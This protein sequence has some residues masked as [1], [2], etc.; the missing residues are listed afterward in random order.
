LRDFFGFNRAKHAIVEAAILA[1][2]TQFLPM[3]E[4]LCEFRRLSVPVQKTAGPD[5]FRAFQFLLDYVN[6]AAERQQ[7]RASSPGSPGEGDNS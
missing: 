5:E 2:R 3:D 7:R 1:T 4:I 6:R